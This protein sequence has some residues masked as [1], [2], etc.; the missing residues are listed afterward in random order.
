[1][2]EYTPKRRTALVLTGSGSAGA[3]HAGVLRALDESG[4]KIDLLV[5]SGAGV[6]AAVYGAVAGGARLSGPE[7][8]WSRIP[9]FFRL[10][11]SLRASAALLFL[12]LAVCV[13]PLPIGLLWALFVPLGLLIDPLLPGSPLRTVLAAPWVDFGT[14]REVY[15]TALAAPSFFLWLFVAAVILRAAIKNRWRLLEYFESPWN[16]SAAEDTLRTGLWEL[17]RGANPAPKAPADSEL[18]KRYVGLA[19]ENLGQPG[20]REVLLRVADLDRGDALTFALLGDGLREAFG[21]SR[22]RPTS[23]GRDARPAVVDL[24]TPGYEGLVVDALLTGLL[25]PLFAPVRRLT[26]PKGGLYA[27]ETHRLCDAGL[28]GGSGLWE[29]LA[30]GAE[31]VIVATAVPSVSELPPRRR[32][33]TAQ[34]D[35][36]IAALERQAVERDLEEAERMNRI[37]ETLGH[38]ASDGRRAWEDPAT[39]RVFRGV[40]LYVVRP[41]IRG[42]GPLEFEGVVDPRTEVVETPEDLAERGYQDAYRLFVAP[43]V[44]ATPDGRW[45]QA[46]RPTSREGQP[47]EL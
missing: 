37:V 44:G 22:T 21:K 9:H 36:A 43:I 2:Q 23:D 32:G 45:R 38:E 13:L 20:F 40:S 30:A 3:Y 7:G 28:V 41:E 18:G 6:I 29:A 33:P 34:A 26:F 4:V 17:V 11:T 27:G 14:F 25:P 46:E 8:L 24:R 16:A 39:G 31:Q 42:L 5:G 35:G 15:L 10:R 1:M 47:V 12:S 19:V